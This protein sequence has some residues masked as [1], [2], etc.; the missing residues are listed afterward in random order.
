MWTDGPTVDAHAYQGWVYDY[1][2]TR[3]NRNGM[4]D[5]NTEVDSIVNPLARSEASRQPPNV[6]GMFINNAFYCCNGLLVFGNGDGR[7]FTFLAGALDVVAHEWTHGVIDFTSQLIYQDESGAL[8]EAFSDIMGATMEFHY[9]PTGGGRDQADWL[10][11]EDVYLL[12]PGYLRSLNN[13]VAGGEPDHYALRQF[14]G[15]PTDDGGVHFN[16]T[17][18]THAFYL[19]VAG[20]QNRFSRI[21]VPGVGMANLER[22][23]RVFYRAF[24]MLMAPNSRFSDARRA[25]I[26]AA[27]D[28]FGAGSNERAQVELAWTAVGVN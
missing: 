18:A 14:I 3:F 9:Q 16:L 11:A 4:D 28:L 7:V 22:I 26:Q 20:G 6:V 21:T 24:T 12:P 27:T 19:A 17:I 2:F 8:N 1:Y 13:P 10:I 23:E 25:T 15:T 5:R